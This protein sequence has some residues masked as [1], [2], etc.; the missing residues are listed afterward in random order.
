MKHSI[1]LKAKRFLNG[2]IDQ[3]LEEDGAWLDWTSLGLSEHDRR[4]RARILAKQDIIV[5]GL[6]VAAQTFHQLAGY[7]VDWLPNVEDGEKAMAN[8]TIAAIEAKAWVILAGE[9]TAINFL[10]RLS[11]IATLTKTYVDKI[12]EYKAKI[13]DTRKTTP[14]FRVLEKYAVRCGGGL[15]HRFGL[16]DGCLIKDNHIHLA[17][18]V[19][20]A[21]DSIRRYIPHLLKIEVEVENLDQV[22]ECLDLGIQALLLDNM[23]IT[24][25]ARTVEIV[26]GR[27]LVEASGGINLEN[28]AG[29]AKTGVDFISVGALTHSALAVDISLELE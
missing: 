4:V 13:I 22:K 26:D 7:G 5:A 14:C 27:I 1:N 19:K 25:I 8:Q 20:Q 2:M 21:V 9:R 15:N 11:G 12:A 23:P 24:E 16:N 28:V 18:G 29:I 10:Q 17:G 3:A 6:D